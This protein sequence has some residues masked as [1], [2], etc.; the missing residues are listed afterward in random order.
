MFI[1]FHADCQ[2]IFGEHQK[3]AVCG[4]ACPNRDLTYADYDRR[5]AENIS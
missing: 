3:G 4:S 1:P 2:D 5:H